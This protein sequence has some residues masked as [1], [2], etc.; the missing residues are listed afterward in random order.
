MVDYHSLLWVYYLRLRFFSQIFLHFIL[1]IV[2]NKV[3][4]DI[5]CFVNFS[6]VQKPIFF[7]KYQLTSEIN[8]METVDIH[9]PTY[10]IYILII[11]L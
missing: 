6:G 8:V 7:I 3:I 11:Q 4:P 1:H 10:V 9:L 5:C 2:I